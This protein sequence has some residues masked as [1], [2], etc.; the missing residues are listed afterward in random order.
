MTRRFGG[1]GMG[2]SIASRLTE[3]LGGDLGVESNPGEGSR[4]TATITTGTIDPETL[5]TIGQ[6]AETNVRSESKASDRPALQGL[7][8]LLAEDGVDNQR[9]IGTQLLT[10]GAT[11]AI[12]RDGL[13]AVEFARR[14]RWDLILMDLQMPNLDGYAATRN[15]RRAGIGT[16][17][18]ALTAHGSDHDRQRALECGCTAHA[19]KPIPPAKLLDLCRRVAGLDEAAEVA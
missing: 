7:R 16:P 17:I 6:R 11:V 18:I 12:A 9:L 5:T 19:T 4:F 2:L 15:L 3:H 13:E 8:V 14:D 1:S 10:T